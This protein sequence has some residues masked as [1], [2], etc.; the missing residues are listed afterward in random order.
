LR[1]ALRGGG[2][3]RRLGAAAGAIEL[4]HGGV[5]AVSRATGLV[6][7]TIRSGIKEL[8]AQPD[9]TPPA[10]KQRKA[11]GGRKKLIHNGSMTAACLLSHT[12]TD[13]FV[14]TPFY[15]IFFITTLSN[16]LCP[17]PVCSKTIRF[18]LPSEYAVN[19]SDR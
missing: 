2:G 7:R 5:M 10:G 12:N 19:V 18:L 8:K 17:D 14:K 4:G 13:R 9:D 11:G 6:P 16:Q 15:S 1:R 3:G